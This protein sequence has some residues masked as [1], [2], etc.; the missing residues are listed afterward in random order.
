MTGQEAPPL[1]TETARV[2]FAAGSGH[3]D[4]ASHLRDISDDLLRHRR[5]A[6]LPMYGGKILIDIEKETPR[7]G[8]VVPHESVLG[9]MTE[10]AVFLGLSGETPC[11]A[12]DFSAMSET[13]VEAQFCDGAT[14]TELRAVAGHLG[15]ASASIAATAKGVVGW[16]QSHAFCSQCGSPSVI[17]NGGWRRKCHTC[18]AQ[19]FPRTDPVVIML[20]VR[21]DMV[22]VGRQAGWPEG[23]YSLLAGYME[24][25]ETIEDAVRRETMEETTVE[26]GP[27]SYIGCQPW[28]FPASL[29]VGCVGV[30]ETEEITIDPEELEDAQWI[31][32]AKM[33][34][35]MEG[36][37]PRLNPPRPDAIAR[38]ILTDWIEGRIEMPWT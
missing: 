28:P 36:K 11:F 32:R 8:W 15:P 27:V 29:M 9:E 2:T 37:H 10:Q 35:I 38:A 24:P 12:A 18:G 1:K 26:V 22:L 17:E 25:G 7:L 34:V 21:D 19:H 16:H 14:F 3:L 31:S 33:Q 30:A 13:E 20:I 6:L 5:A 23:I 4:R